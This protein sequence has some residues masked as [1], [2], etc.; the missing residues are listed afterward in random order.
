MNHALEVRV[1]ERLR[2]LAADP[3]PIVQEQVP[4]TIREARPVHLLHDQEVIPFRLTEVVQP[5]DLVVNQPG[6][7]LRLEADLAGFLPAAGILQRI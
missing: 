4:P 7:D 5:H 6:E 3:Q 2:H 1:I